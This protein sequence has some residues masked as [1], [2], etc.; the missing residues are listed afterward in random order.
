MREEEGGAAGIFKWPDDTTGVRDEATDG[1]GGGSARGAPDAT[2]GG[3][4]D[5]TLPL[6]LP[7]LLVTAP[8]W[9][10]LDNDEFVGVNDDELVAVVGLVRL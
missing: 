9:D 6:L 8:L 10:T 5:F 7:L 2:V 1:R 3:V 4:N